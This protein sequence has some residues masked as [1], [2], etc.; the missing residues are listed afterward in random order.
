MR[1]PRVGR[2]VLRRLLAAAL[3]LITIGAGPAAQGPETEPAQ[4]QIARVDRAA[5]RPDGLW[6]GRLSIAAGR[7]VHNAG[8]RRSYELRWFQK[9]DRRRLDLYSAR[10]G[11][12]AR[13][14]YRDDGASIW[15]WDQTRFRLAHIRDGERFRPVLQSGF[16]FADLAAQ[17]LEQHYAAERRIE[18][19]QPAQPN[20]EVLQTEDAGAA[21]VGGFLRFFLRPVAAPVDSRAYGRIVVVIDP[22]RGDRLLRRDL[23]NADRVL[24]R[25]L[26]YHY[27]S[28][29]LLRSTGAAQRP[30]GVATRLEMLDLVSGENSVIEFHE[31]DDVGVVPDEFFEPDN[32]NR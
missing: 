20:A 16:Y 26:R 28:E 2:R 3:L 29:V 15:F 13:V 5:R 4:V 8:E 30:E 17:P 1:S 32:L 31:F 25:T 18:R 21:P 11:L 6:L 7:T 10:R 12:E 19:Y 14:L 9:G 24:T 22:T 23:F 27:D